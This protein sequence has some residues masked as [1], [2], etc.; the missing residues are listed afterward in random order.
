MKH[1]LRHI[2]VGSTFKRINVADIK[3]LTVIVPLREEQDAISKLLDSELAGYDTAIHRAER[4]IRLLRE[5]R[6][7]GLLRTC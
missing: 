6:R 2:L 7:N 4:E 1:Q 3:A 5:Y